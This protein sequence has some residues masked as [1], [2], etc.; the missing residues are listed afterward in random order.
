MADFTLLVGDGDGTKLTV[1]IDKGIPADTR[2]PVFSAGKW[3][4]AA[5]IGAA[6]KQGKVSWDDK[7]GKHIPFW[8]TDPKDARSDVTF[9]SCMSLTSGLVQATPVWESFSPYLR[10]S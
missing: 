3:I 8:P 7:V 10:I 6:V 1:S 5:A 2:M 9:R 4:T